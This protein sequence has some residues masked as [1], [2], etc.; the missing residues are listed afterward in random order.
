MS[1]KILLIIL[2]STSIFA[3]T[4]VI[5]YDA[6]FGIFGTVG[7]LTNTITKT[8]HTY[9]IKTRLTL[10]G[11]AKSLFGGQTGNYIS[12]G[13]IRNGLFITTQYKSIERYNETKTVST[14]YINH[15][16]R[17]VTKDFKEY[18]KAKLV[19]HTKKRLNFYAKDDLLTLYFNMDK[20][21]KMRKSGKRYIFKVVGLEKQNG[22]VQITIP[23]KSQYSSYK[24]DLGDTANWYAKALIYQKN[25]KKKKGDILLSVSRDGN[26]KKAII[27]DVILYG[28]ASLVRV[29]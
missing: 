13:F 27:K 24:S 25:F 26:I 8:K 11:L 16:R 6:K 22:N 12:K 29:K 18:K 19:K 14:Y 17:Y 7:K 20:N 28:D 1:K 9:T 10:T 5:N 15:K 4:K 2:L 21:V 23:S 3:S